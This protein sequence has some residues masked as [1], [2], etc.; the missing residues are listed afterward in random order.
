MKPRHWSVRGAARQ[1][2]RHQRMMEEFAKLEVLLAIRSG[3]EPGR[4]MRN[5]RARMRRWQKKLEMV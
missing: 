5:T 4:L 3:A 1:A 2:M